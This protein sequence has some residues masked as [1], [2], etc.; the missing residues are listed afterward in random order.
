MKRIEEYIKREVV[1]SSSK[2]IDF[3]VESL[4]LSEDNARKKVQ[5]L[6]SSSIIKIKGICSK[7]QS[8]LYHRDSPRD[9]TFYSHLMDTLSINAQQHF[10]VLNAL[11]LHGGFILKEKLASFSISPIEDTKGHK[12]FGSVIEDLKRLELIKESSSNYSLSHSPFSEAR[13]K[14]IDL[15][16]TITREH[17]HEWARNIG[18]ISYN[19]AKF[20]SKFSRYQFS[21]VA[22]SYIKSLTS[23]KEKKTPA[24]LIADILLNNT[25]VTT[26]DI[27]FFIKKIENISHQNNQARFIPFLLTSTHDA[28]IYQKLKKSGIIIGNIDELFG[29][30]YTESIFGLLNLI[31]NAGAILK[32]NPDQY[33]KLIENIEK[34]AI[35]KTYNLKGALFE[36]AVGLFH[37]SQCQSLE[38]SKRIYTD[39]KEVEVDVYAVYQD[40]VVFAE[41]KGYNSPIG[42]KYVENWLSQKTPTIRNWALGQGS[43]QNKEIHFEIWS[44]GG[45]SEQASERLQSMKEKTKKYS[46]DYFD[47]NQM[48]SLAKKK[49]TNHFL[50]IIKEY[51]EKT[52]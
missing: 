41:C 16:Q 42:D 1:T 6:P 7:R 46:I 14:A 48:K 47:I 27:D 9:E 5:L 28:D 20:D 17:F 51:Y 18:L 30:K 8:I 39:T 4:G 23:G 43:L 26:S 50:K 31:E 35:G 22:P 52:I 25:K 45:F 24:F 19:S 44:T 21:L 32:K 34:I 29:K 12:S 49:R 10:F 11:Q 13:S 37:G 33:I 38:I 36:M 40:H 2:V 15:V 3:C